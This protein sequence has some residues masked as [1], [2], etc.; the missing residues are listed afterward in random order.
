MKL[1]V[2]TR[3]SALARVQAGEVARRLKAAGHEPEIVALS[4]EG[5]RQADRK[6]AE[7]GAFGVFVRDIEARLLAGNVDLAVHSY[8]DLPSAGPAGLEIAAVPER[9]DPADVLLV[10]ADAVA[11]DGTIPVREGARIGTSSARRRALLL[12]LRPDLV[13]SPL[14]G[15][16]PTRVRALA[17]GRF[18]AIVL[19]GAGLDRLLASGEDLPL[20]EGIV[21]TRLDP[22]VFVP[23]PA[24]GAI[25]VQVRGDNDA[26]RQ[27][28]AALNDPATGQALRAE[29]AALAK[30]DA[31]CELAFGAWC[32]VGDD[33]VLTLALAM[34]REDALLHAEASDPDPETVAEVA[35]QAL[36]AGRPV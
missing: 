30:A 9:R 16:V 8:K 12:D 28:V 17:A 23:A 26:V 19:A 7:I 33:G 6:F 24:Q 13:V 36:G 35:W 18:D 15:N 10:R 25:A 22:S 5:D 11:N 29:R 32:R 31:G 20:D 21:R 34:E 27:A 3:R 1:R 14:R 2:G 4:T